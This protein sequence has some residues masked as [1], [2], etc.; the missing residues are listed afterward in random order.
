MVTTASRLRAEAVIEHPWSCREMGQGFFIW[1]A[2]RDDNFQHIH[3]RTVIRRGLALDE[4]LTGPP[5]EPESHFC[6]N[7]E[8]ELC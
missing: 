8:G 3:S 6:P 1:S 5:H 2:R 4:P 7:P